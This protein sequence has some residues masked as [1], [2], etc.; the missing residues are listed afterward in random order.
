MGRSLVHRLRPAQVFLYLKHLIPFGQPQ[1][2]PTASR[3]PPDR[4]ATRLPC[5]GRSPPVPPDGYEQPFR[6]LDRS[7]TFSDTQRF[8]KTHLQGPGVPR[9]SS[10]RLGGSNQTQVRRHLSREV[11]LGAS[12]FA[13]PSPEM[14]STKSPAR[15]RLFP[16]RSNVI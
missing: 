3:H 14:G 4:V 13:P 9:F 16:R 2:Q 12:H 7:P 15:A 11:L 6:W 1:G 10:A 8:Q 5:L